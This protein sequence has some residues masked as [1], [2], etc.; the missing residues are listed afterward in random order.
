MFG[1]DGAGRGGGGGGGLDYL[2]SQLV[3]RDPVTLLPLR[4]ESWMTTNTGYTYTAKKI[5]FMYSLM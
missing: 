1:S 4:G 5:R 3:S 2:I